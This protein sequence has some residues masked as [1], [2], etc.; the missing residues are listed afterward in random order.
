MSFDM[1]EIIQTHVNSS[2]HLAKKHI[3]PRLG[4]M[5]QLG[6]QNTV[7]T[8]AEGAHLL[9]ATG[10]RYLDL[11]AGGGVHFIGRNHPT[12][13]KAIRDVTELD[14][15]NLCVVNSSILG[16]LLAEK[17]TN[18][19]GGGVGKVQFANSG[20]EATDISIRFARYVTGRRRFLYLEGAFHG[21]SYAAISVCGF[22]QMKE[23]M[24][25]IMPTVTPL[26]VNDIEQ[27]RR[28]I[29]KGDCA[30][31]LY[32]AVQGMTCNVI[33]PAWL[34]EAEKLCRQYDTMLIADEVQTGL[35]RLGDTWFAAQ[36]YGVK[37]DMMNVS[38]TLSGGQ[39]PISCTIVADSVYERV[40]AKFKHGPIYFST[41]AE[42]NIAMAAGLATLH[43]LEE[44]NAPK[45][46]RELSDQ[47][48]AGLYRI[49]EKY[50]CI[51]RIA[52]KGLMIAIYF[53]DSKKKRLRVQQ[54]VM[55]AADAG[56]FGASV[57]V[58]MYR[59]Q[60]VIT[61]LPGPDLNAIKILPPVMLSDSDVNWFLNSFDDVMGSYYKSGGPIVSLGKA[62]VNSAIKDAKNAIPGLS[63]SG[64]AIDDTEKKTGADVNSGT[65]EAK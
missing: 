53:R 45:R 17:L 52:G 56:S 9:T 64:G 10:E 26:R 31:L 12:V 14:V 22:P 41:F 16:G 8:R 23:G 43:V 25:P 20:T 35:A 28:E 54:E 51:D 27:L 58:E 18:L 29:S 11:L 46:A 2:D 1:K 44:M 57:N 50:D 19:A 33:D 49:A 21:R 38:K 3:H 61:Q 39:V 65:A 34:R 24:D 32:E 15:P 48:R 42:N 60:R 55:G 4:K 30:G 62:V 7:F 63:G 13:M 40:Y 37:P 36:Q 47:L 5:L 6:G 59:S